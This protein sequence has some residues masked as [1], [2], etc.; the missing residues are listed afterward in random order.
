MSEVF[1]EPQTLVF[2]FF[3]V[4]V[5]RRVEAAGLAHHFDKKYA[6]EP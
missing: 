1:A 6:R 4:Q 5:N 2:L 3:E